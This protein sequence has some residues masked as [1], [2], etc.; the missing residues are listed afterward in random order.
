MGADGVTCATTRCGTCGH[1]HISH[2]LELAATT[3]DTAINALGLQSGIN[4]WHIVGGDDTGTLGHP[5]GITARIIPGQRGRVRDPFFLRRLYSASLARGAVDIYCDDDGRNQQ[6]DAIDFRSAA[7]PATVANLRDV[8]AVYA[9][10]PS[11]LERD[12]LRKP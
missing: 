4:R 5:S 2:Q 8:R 6:P 12:C 9:F 7:R 10:P 11:F 3:F 1:S